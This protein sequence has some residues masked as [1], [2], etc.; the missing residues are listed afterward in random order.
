MF[1]VLFRDSIPHS[2]RSADNLHSDPVR[3][4]K[5]LAAD[6]AQRFQQWQNAASFRSLYACVSVFLDFMQYF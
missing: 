3:K 6:Y 2:K 5:E 1:R 4:E